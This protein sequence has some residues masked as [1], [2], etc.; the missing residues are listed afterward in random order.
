MRGEK[1][2]NALNMI[3][4]WLFCDKMQQPLVWDGKNVFDYN[5]DEYKENIHCC[6]NYVEKSIYGL[7]QDDFFEITNAIRKAKEN[8]K[9]SNFPDFVFE[10]GFIEHFQ[11]TASKESKKKGSAEMA[12]Q[13]RFKRETQEELN[14]FYKY[15]NENPSLNEVRSKEWTRKNIPE[16][17]YE[18]LKSS[19]KTN[20]EKHLDSLDKYKGCKDL[21]IFLIE[22][23]E[24]NIEMCENTFKEMREGLRCDYKMRQEHF[25]RYMLS[26]DK[27]MLTYIY[28]FKHKI[29]YIIYY[30]EESFE[31]IK[32]E[33]IP[34]LFK[35]IPNEY[36]IVPRHI[37]IT[38]RVSNITTK[39]SLGGN[40]E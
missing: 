10:N 2:R 12:D 15:C 27:N 16:Y 8:S 3:K 20:L 30:Y 28:T 25:F 22:N 18:N 5:D 11:I 7:T 39:F 19:F 31:I 21:S 14:E 13:E 9:P 6:T 26:R 24:V 17:S 23:S 1:E 34:D 37:Q 29:D 36:I 33:N 35:F 4:R 32:V 38:H 40:N